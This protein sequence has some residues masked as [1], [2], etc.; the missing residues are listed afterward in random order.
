M[1]AFEPLDTSFFTTPQLPAGSRRSVGHAPSL[2]PLVL[3]TSGI[4][5]CA[6]RVFEGARART[7][8]PDVAM[9]GLSSRIKGLKVRRTPRPGTRPSSSPR[10]PITLPSARHPDPAAAPPPP[11][12]EDSSWRAAERETMAAAAEATAE[13]EAEKRAAER[14]HAPGFEPGAE[15][16]DGRVVV[17]YLPEA[18]SMRRKAPTRISFGGFNKE[19]ERRAE[20]NA[21]RERRI[22][23]AAAAARERRGRHRRGDGS[24]ADE[25]RGRRATEEE[26]I[27]GRVP[28]TR[29]PRA[30]RRSEET[31]REEAMTVSRGDAWRVDGRSPSFPFGS[32]V[33][34]RV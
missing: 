20:E 30:R 5:T 25:A 11:S 33:G 18:P 21:A 28:K 9:S 3:F 32:R 13:A 26:N 24:R 16:A 14:W 10:S 23:T 8:D 7:H 29:A 6:R 12:R 34:C 19:T 27:R 22:K 2:G 4:V 15:P 1:C 31:T 17:T